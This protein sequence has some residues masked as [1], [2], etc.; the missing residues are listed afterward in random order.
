[1]PRGLITLCSMAAR[2]ANS[3]E[4]RFLC[5]R[6]GE[7]MKDPVVD[8]DGNSYERVNILVWLDDRGKSPL[9]GRF[10]KKEELKPN[11]ILKDTIDYALEEQ[12]RRTDSEHS[13]PTVSIWN[14]VCLHLL[15]CFF[16]IYK[17]KSQRKI[18]EAHSV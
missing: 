10:M 16:K 14:Q 11:H 4:A 2:K 3:Y 15:D 17:Q 13:K 12:R 7:L 8:A 6:S 1:M 5:P 18:L 9:T